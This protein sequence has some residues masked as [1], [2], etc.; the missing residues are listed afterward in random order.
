MRPETNR[1]ATWTV[2]LAD[3][4]T[5]FVAAHGSMLTRADARVVT[6]SSATHALD[7]ARAEQPVLVVL[8]ADTWGVEALRALRADPATASIPVLLV[9]ARRPRDP[10]VGADAWLA[11]PIDPHELECA[12]AQIARRQARAAARRHVA[13]RTTYFHGARSARAFTKDVGTGG[14]FLRVRESLAVGDPVQV[15]VDLPGD[16]KSAVRAAGEV[17]RLVPSERDSHLVPG[18]ALRFLRISPRDRG[19]LARFVAS[20]AADG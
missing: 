12:A 10:K 5:I 3:D 13:L 11:R 8:D 17:A 20:G 16:P 15:I 1:E 2:L 14:V 4:P 7:K 6:A 18:I 19:K 9:H